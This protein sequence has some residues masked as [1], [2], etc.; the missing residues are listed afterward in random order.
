MCLWECQLKV[1][2]PIQKSKLTQALNYDIF[3]IFV[4]IG[5]LY[6]ASQRDTPMMASNRNI[7]AT[8]ISCSNK[9][10]TQVYEVLSEPMRH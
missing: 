7:S 3:W 8:V 9:L 6:H 10:N 5:C 2:I 4:A 1:L